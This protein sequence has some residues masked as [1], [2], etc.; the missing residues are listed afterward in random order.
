MSKS[1]ECA[2]RIDDE[3][4]FKTWG[5]DK[6]KAVAEAWID[7]SV[8]DIVYGGSK[9]SGKSFL[10]C[11]LIFGDALMYPGTHYFIARR[12][13]NDLRKYTRSSVEEVMGLWNIPQKMYKYDGKDNFYALSNGSIVY[14]VEAAY[15]PQDQ[16]FARLGSMQMTRGWIEEAGEILEAAKNNLAATV[17]RWKNIEYGLK[18]KILQT[19]NPVKNYL[20]REYYKK[21]REGTLPNWQRFIQALPTDNKKGSEDYI[22]NLRRTLSTNEKERLLFGNWEYDDDPTVLCG[23]DA[24]SDIFTNLHVKGTGIRYITA[25]IA[26]MGQDSTVIRVW[27]GWRVI[28]RIKGNKLRINESADMIRQAATK[29]SVPMSNVLVDEDGIG[30]GV[31]D[32]LRCKGFVANSVPLFIGEY[33]AQGKEVKGNFDNLKS[34]CA[35]KMAEK[36]NASSVYESPADSSVQ[37]LLV[38]QFEQLKQ[39]SLDKV[40][41]KGIIPKDQMKAV[42]GYSPDDLD[43]WIMR[44]YFDIRKP[45]APPVM[46]RYK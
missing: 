18:G 6:Q 37:D 9:Y 43:T 39:K 45:S 22:E 44:G 29:Y 10:G 35:F 17:G 42:L 7:D 8:F 14:F 30:G 31:V 12:E 19:C 4:I 26:R 28:A 21:N 33:D 34:Q 38:E 1:E 16:L 32:L 15:K 46:M 5:N 24:I 40:E 25:D 3:I 27:D 36:V 23:Y 11:S 20:Y 41:K 13:L 2:L